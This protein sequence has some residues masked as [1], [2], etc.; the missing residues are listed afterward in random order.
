MLGCPCIDKTV[1]FWPLLILFACVSCFESPSVGRE[2]E[3]QQAADATA[4]V[5]RP[6]G[7]IS[8]GADLIPAGDE[9]ILDA[10]LREV[11]TRTRT[12][13]IVVTVRSLSG[14]DIAAYTDTLARQWEVG[15][16]RGGVVL[17]VAPNER[18]M[19]ISTSEDVRAR[20]SDKQCAEIIQQVLA[21]HFRAGN[22][23]SG[24][25]AGVE[26]IASHL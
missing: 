6:D 15:A 4:L 14:Q 8:D 13:L 11:L 26:A 20:L 22:F 25:A 10:R 7:P 16:E 23:S 21:P 9:A 3:A 24:I 12:A 1:K 18:R 2:Q 5:P 17:L 19:R